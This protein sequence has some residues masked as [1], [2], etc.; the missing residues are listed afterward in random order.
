MIERTADQERAVE[1]E[2]GS[3]G[4]ALADERGRQRIG[5]TY[6]AAAHLD[7]TQ[8]MSVWPRAGKSLLKLIEALELSRPVEA[9]LALRGAGSNPRFRGSA[10]S[11][12]SGRYLDG[13][14]SER[15]VI[16]FGLALAAFNR[17][18]ESVE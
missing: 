7:S 12:S 17:I 9:R 1:T 2:H 16:V 4:E 3:A 8:D 6:T 11:Q 5:R 18:L 13:L 10:H 14:K 15:I